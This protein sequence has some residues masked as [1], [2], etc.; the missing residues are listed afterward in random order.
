MKAA[1]RSLVSTLVLLAVAAAALAAAFFGI[2]KKDEAKEAKKAEEEK[3]YAFAPAKVKA[4]AVEAKGEATALARS[5]DG[6][7]IE[8]PVKAGAERATVD[9][10]VD[11]IAELRRKSTI[12]P[13]PDGA[14]LARYGLEKPRAKVTLTLDDG[15]SESLALGDE[16]AF[17]G[18]AFVRTTGG[19]IELVPGEVKWS[20][21]R[22]TFDLR[23]KRL[24]PFEDK[25]LQ[26]ISIVAPKL[27]YELA[28]EGDAWRLAAPARERADEATVSRVLSALRG[29][30]ATAFSPA[31]GG[32]SARGLEEPRWT[33]KLVSTAGTRTLRIG[34]AP[35]AG[36]GDAGPRPLHARLDGADE[37]ATLPEDAGKDLDQDLFALRD[38][39]VLRF[40]REK[41]AAVK[42]TQDGSS[43]EGKKDAAP[44]RM[45]SLLWTLSSL[46][47]KAFADES[48]RTI[49]EHGLDRPAREVALLGSDG[50][51]LDHLYVSAARGGRTFARSAS[52]PRI[53]E[54]DGSALAALPKSAQDLEEKPEAKPAAEAKAGRK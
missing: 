54:I 27:S 23:E 2:A 51:E 28:R 50:K 47:A 13:A 4:I 26:R 8:S 34:E 24:L 39:A 31:R 25:D 6:W 42:L 19:A 5:G 37:V 9:A 29:L 1:N 32:E 14:A 11:R 17:D 40:D 36:K 33:V 3:L 10:L 44:G 7:R 18:T 30:R 22:S 20:V 48:G 46:Q 45:A 21:E 16:N 52:S 35:R 53:V 12:A 38:K 49:A 41:V 43:F 15:K